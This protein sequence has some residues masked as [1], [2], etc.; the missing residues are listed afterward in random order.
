MLLG[1]FK[2]G[3]LWL[4]L[5]IS[6]YSLSLS[7]IPFIFGAII[8]FSSFSVGFILFAS[9]SCQ[10]IFLFS[11]GPVLFVNYYIFYLLAL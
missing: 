9:S 7:F 3:T 10:L 5:S 6:S 1:P 8:L 4:I 2:I 11:L